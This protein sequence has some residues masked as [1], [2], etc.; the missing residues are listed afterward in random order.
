MAADRRTD[1]L[2]NV[3]L[4]VRRPAYND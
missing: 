3:I 1:L 4:G 2:L